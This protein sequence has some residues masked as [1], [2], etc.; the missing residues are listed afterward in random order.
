MS[1]ET[2]LSS[3][4]HVVW[5]VAAGGRLGVGNDPVY[6]TS[7]CFDPYPFPSTTL[8][9]ERGAPPCMAPEITAAN[10]AAAAR[11]HGNFVRVVATEMDLATGLPTGSSFLGD[12]GIPG[13]E[14]GGFAG[15][16]EFLLG[17]TVQIDQLLAAFGRQVVG[18]RE[19]R[20]AD[21]GTEGQERRQR[22]SQ[23]GRIGDGRTCE[24]DQ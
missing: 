20:A 14:F 1:S 18:S 17:S 15:G 6:T 4:F 19:R 16:V 23:Q 21:D 8:G 3:R 12:L 22:T 24:T 2:L 11:R 5:V 13:L 10:I 9:N 7:K